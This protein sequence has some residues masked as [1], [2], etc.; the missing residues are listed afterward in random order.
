MS[1]SNQISAD[2][3]IRMPPYPDAPLVD[4]EFQCAKC[5]RT[6]KACVEITS[7]LAGRD[8]ETGSGN[9][10]WGEII[11]CECSET[12]ELWGITTAAGWTIKFEDIIKITGEKEFKDV[13]NRI[14]HDA[15]ES[16]T[17]LWYRSWELFT[18][19]SKKKK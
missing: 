11:D 14:F 8:P 9:W 10:G 18:R 6:H 4:V 3:A 12:C 15:V 19:K 13:T 2:Q 17:R 1:W 16:V 5:G 7:Y